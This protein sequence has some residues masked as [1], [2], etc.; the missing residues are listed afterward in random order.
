MIAR[1]F[2]ANAGVAALLVHAA[3]NGKAIG[4]VADD[5]NAPFQTDL[6]YAWF[7]GANYTFEDKGAQLLSC[8]A[9]ISNQAAC[10]G[11]SLA[12]VRIDRGVLALVRSKAGE[13]DA[14]ELEPDCW[15]A[16][17]SGGTPECSLKV[18]G[19]TCTGL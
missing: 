11:C 13:P 17:P 2:A 1:G 8:R 19:R 14:R 5:L 9:S 18:A 4:A 6:A 15:L 16:A 3:K 10:D 7:V 12:F